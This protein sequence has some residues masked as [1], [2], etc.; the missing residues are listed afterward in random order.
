MKMIDN[1]NHI[2]ADD[3]KSQLT[4]GAKLKVAASYFSIYAYQAL[5]NV[6]HWIWNPP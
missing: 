2:L 5:K 3:L 4:S 6:R 1:I